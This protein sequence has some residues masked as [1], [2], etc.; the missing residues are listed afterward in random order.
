MWSNHRIK[1]KACLYKSWQPGL[2][3]CF[4]ICRCSKCA[5]EIFERMNTQFASKLLEITTYELYETFSQVYILDFQNMWKSLFLHTISDMASIQHHKF[6][7][8]MPGD[9]DQLLMLTSFITVRYFWCYLTK[10]NDME[11]LKWIKNWMTWYVVFWRS[12]HYVHFWLV[13]STKQ[14]AAT[15]VGRIWIDRQQT[16]DTFRIL[17]SLSYGLSAHN[18]HLFDYHCIL[19]L[20]PSTST[21]SSAVEHFFINSILVFFK[22]GYSI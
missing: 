5:K 6:I 20:F 21:S 15:A 14:S 4:Q 16:N 17:Y 19:Y 7:Y 9:S 12:N 11:F 8:F 2:V 22:R 13:L 1:T 18:V 10:C 3:L